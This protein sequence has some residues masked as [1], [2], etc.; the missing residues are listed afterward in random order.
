MFA[1]K[2]KST[3]KRSAA[4]ASMCVLTAGL[5]LSCKDGGTAASPGAQ[6]SEAATAG[7][8]RPA[9]PRA[10][11]LY[12][13]FTNGCP[14]WMVRVPSPPRDFCIDRFEAYAT[15]LTE[16]GEAPHPSSVP[17]RNKRILAKVAPGA[18]PQSSV[19][20]FQADEACRNAGK[21][22]CTVFEWKRACM[23][24]S[25]TIF[26]YGEKEVAGKCNTRKVHIL[27]VF[28][29]N[30]NKKWSAFD[31]NNPMLNK[32]EGFLAKTGAYPE[33][34]SGYGT[35]DQV[36][37][38]HE[39]VSDLVDERLAGSMGVS[40]GDELKARQK[41]RE[42]VGH[43]IFMGGF[44]STGAQNGTGCDYMTIAHLPDHFDYSTGFRCCGDAAGMK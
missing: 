43:G 13:G 16:N 23:G 6:P 28:S 9:S 15:E 8:S 7:P 38:L 27:S 14:E 3:A 19:N 12:P 31:M 42:I 26:P 35:Y 32:L 25:G 5:M 39:W 40:G 18:L 34:R 37:N 1:T 17:P 33:C 24:P 36:G 20:R 30:D 29:G 44:Y 10:D 21:R 22:L 4:F 2:V 41:I 11:A